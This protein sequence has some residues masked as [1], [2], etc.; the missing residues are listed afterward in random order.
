VGNDSSDGEG[1]TSDDASPVDDD[2]DLDALRTAAASMMPL[3]VGGRVSIRPLLEWTSVVGD[4]D[5]DG[6]RDDG[7][8]GRMAGKTSPSPSAAQ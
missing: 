7:W 6:R 4:D 1:A 2:D 5:D 3:S 8:C